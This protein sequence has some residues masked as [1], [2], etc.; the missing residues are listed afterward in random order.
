MSR[1]Q[2]DVHI[3]PCINSTTNGGNVIFY[4]TR[5]DLGIFGESKIIIG[6]TGYK[7]PIIDLNGQYATTE[8]AFSFSI[9]N[10]EDV[11]T[12]LGDLKWFAKNQK[13]FLWLGYRIEYKIFKHI[14][15]GFSNK[16]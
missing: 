16:L 10:D 14:K 11:D 6:E 5:N 8:S 1:S 4:S 3:Y 7:T 9:K 12:I 2:D 15:Y 13:Y